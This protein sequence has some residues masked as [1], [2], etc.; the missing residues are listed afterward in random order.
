MILRYQNLCAVGARLLSLFVVVAATG[1][2]A[3][4]QAPADPNA[5]THLVT[6]VVFPEQNGSYTITIW[7]AGPTTVE[8]G[9][10]FRVEADKEFRLIFDNAQTLIWCG[11][12]LPKEKCDAIKIN[13]ID[14]AVVVGREVILAGIPKNYGGSHKVWLQLDDQTPIPSGPGMALSLSLVVWWVPV[15]VAGGILV[16]LVLIVL[17]LLYN[18][19]R[20]RTTL[21]TGKAITLAKAIFIDTQTST[22]SL[23]K[24]QFYVWTFA[25]LGGYLYLSV[26]RSLVQG[27]L[28]LSDVPSNLP[29]II[30]ISVGTSVVA[31][32]VS[33]MAGN[34]GAGDVDPTPSDLIT[35]GGVVAPERLQ[36]LLWTIVGG[37][38]FLFYTLAI[39]PAEIQNLPEIPAGFLELMGISAA[40]YVGGKLV[41]G[42]GPKI[43]AISGVLDGPPAAGGFRGIT[44]TVDGTY[45]ASAGATFFMAV[46]PAGAAAPGPDVPVHPDNLPAQTAPTYL[47][48]LRLHVPGTQVLAFAPGTKYRFTIV[49]P[50]AEKASWDFTTPP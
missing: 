24:L 27:R 28:M 37:L 17:W 15:V 23:S 1:A 47:T 38:A 5:V 34:K 2:T 6:S 11:P 26:A 43:T 31:T 41:R 50:D 13:K 33:T 29:G 35:S 19:G 20:L 40:G 16:A 36:Y 39:S 25:G 18:G 30:L 3:Q 49:N 21:P 46:F 7:I 45:L 14:S 44:L 8:T 12:N 32:G 22:Y 10:E 48:Q 4:A 42:S 9:K